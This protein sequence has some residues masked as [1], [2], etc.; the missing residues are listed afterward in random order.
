MQKRMGRFQ[1]V[2]LAVTF[3]SSMAGLFLLPETVAVQW[4]HNG[5]SN[6][7]IQSGCVLD[8]FYC[9]RN[10]RCRVESIF[11]AFSNGNRSK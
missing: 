2:L 6:F 5:V 11:R 1:V 3:A 9:E 7:S 8:S 10:L 4:N